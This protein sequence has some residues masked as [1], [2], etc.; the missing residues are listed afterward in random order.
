MLSRRE[1]IAGGA[2]VHMAAGGAAAAQREVDDGPEL[3]SIRDVLI[4]IR[5]DH[6]VLT[7][8]VRDLRTQQRNF[9]RLNQRFPQ[10]IDVGI[11]VWE[12]MQDWHIA[13]LRPLTIQ[14]TSD[15]HW[16]MDFIMSVIVL[17]HELPENEIGLGYDR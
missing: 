1:L 17:K 7:S 13:H 11:G 4:G 10:C 8:T 5:Q 12:R 15:G 3:N 16:Q 14:R 6:A 9:F 2:A